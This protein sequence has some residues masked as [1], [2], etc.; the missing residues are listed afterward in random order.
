MS[1]TRNGHYLDNA[2]LEKLWN[3][4]KSTFVAKVSGKG[5]STNDYTT[6]EKNKLAGIAAGAEVNVQSDWS[7]TSSSSDA[8][9]KNKPTSMKNPYALSI[10]G[11]TYDGSSAQTITLNDLDVY[12]KV[13]VDNLFSTNVNYQVVQALPVEGTPGVIYLVPSSEGTSS[14]FYEE[15]MY[16][17]EANNVAAHFERIG[18]TQTS[19]TDYVQR[20]SL[21]SA[22]GSSTKPV[23]V[24]ADGQV[25]A[26]S[27]YAGGTRVAT[28]NG[29]N[30]AATSIASIYA[31][32]GAGAS[33]QYL[34]SNGSGAPTWQSF[35]TTP[36]SESTIGIT[37]G[38]V[39][40]ALQA[41]VN[42]ADYITDAEI[43]AICV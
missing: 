41:K 3:L 5:L 35:D 18:S 33:E 29:A 43:T 14:D 11:K 23:Y 32:V 4:I 26:C 19:I 7:V 36:T 6:E 15:Y 39:Y 42:T 20:A 24:K 30:A 8:Y 38:G 37:S 34:K 1:V 13:E 40:T 2:G 25:A 12:S 16:V 10:G 9:I 22:T 27:T 17:P 28:F 31:P 21:S